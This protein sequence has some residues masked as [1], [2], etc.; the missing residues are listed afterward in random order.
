M[1]LVKIY[2]SDLP[3]QV[4][5][6]DDE[7]SRWRKIREIFISGD[8]R[9]NLAEGYENEVET[10]DLAK[11]LDGIENWIEALLNDNSFVVKTS[12]YSFKFKGNHYFLNTKKYNIDKEITTLNSL[13]KIVAFCIKASSSLTLISNV[14]TSRD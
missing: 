11:V 7:L 14:T 13:R 9:L 10:K 4:M 3:K 8:I 2:S 5:F 6:I 1:T 12:G